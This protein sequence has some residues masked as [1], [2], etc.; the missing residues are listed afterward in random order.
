MPDKALYLINPA[1]DFPTYFGGEVYAGRGFAPAALLADLALPTI[2]ALAPPD[3]QV[4]LCDQHLTPVNYDARAPFVGITGKITQFGRMIAL[5]REFR[6]RG[7]V[8]LIGGPYA[9]LCPE[10]VRPHCDILVRGEI[11]NIAAGLFADLAASCWK[12]EYVG[13]KPDLASSPLPR[14]DLYP[15]GRALMGA[16]QT[17][18]GCPF[19]CEFCDVIQY[20][21]RKQRH[22]APAQ[23]LAELDELYRHGYRQVFLADDNFTIYR[24][25]AKELLAALASWNARLE[26]GKVAFGTQ[27]SIDAA[28]DEE[29]L[30]M[31]AEAGVT[32][33]FIGIETPNA[34]SLRETKKHQNLGIDLVG[35][36]QRF[37]DH[38]IWVI[39]GMIVGFDA[40]GPDIFRRQYEFAMSTPVPIFSVGALVAPA[41]TPLYARLAKEGRLV[42][43]GGEAAG[44]P[45]G[46]NILPRQMTRRQLLDGTRR[47]CGR[48]YSPSAFGERLFRFIDRL[49]PRRDPRRAQRAPRG[50]PKRSIDLDGVDL[51]GTFSRLGSE[52]AALLAALASRLAAKPEASEFVAQMLHQ[53]LQI[54]YVYEQGRLGAYPG[55]AWPEEAPLAEPA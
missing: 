42:E 52:E 23:V 28:K 10:A 49:G 17:S 51:L 8:V 35:Q 27:V 13:D 1:A 26:N 12:E 50:G 3:F 47:L 11:E 9:S 22:K 40:D 15:N 43:D 25:R 19:E 7:K 18:R 37:L 44:S 29:L 16:V 39:A 30:R 38:G 21:G 6:R 53:Y 54:R 31:C 41:A 33:V 14:W 55:S 46:T 4:S 20:L 36:V 45:W 2:A 24:S 32:Q 34:G 48:L 5:A